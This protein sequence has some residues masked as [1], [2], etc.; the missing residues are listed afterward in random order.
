M[1]TSA[2]ASA[3]VLVAASVCAQTA[4]SSFEVASVKPNPDPRVSRFQIQ[5]GGQLLITGGSVEAIV[6]R[7]F[8]VVAGDIVGLPSWAKSE[9]F[10]IRAK[11]AEAST[12]PTQ[13]LILLQALLAER[14]G[15]KTHRAQ[16]ER[17]IYRLTRDGDRPLGPNLRPSSAVCDWSQPNTGGQPPAGCGVS[18]RSVTETGTIGFIFYGRSMA[19]LAA[20]LRRF[21]DRHV[22]DE[23]GLTERYDA[24]V[25]FVPDTATRRDGITLFTAVREQLG[26]RLQPDRGP[27]DLLVVDAIARPTPD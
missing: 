2:L 8:G 13:T 21:V 16:E 7:A 18:T 6:E 3:L 5:P 12:S 23:S 25:H 15:L 1:R 14:F 4:P 9:K 20:D 17:P 10:D 27:V 22:E 26:L 19:R 24:E 11:A